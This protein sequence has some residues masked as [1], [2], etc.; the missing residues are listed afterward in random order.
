M[1]S[2]L[3]IPIVAA[4][5]LV[6]LAPGGAVEAR[7]DEG[8]ELARRVAEACGVDAFDDLA[9]LR[10]TWRHEPSGTVRSYDWD[11]A[12]RTV[13]VTVGEETVTVGVDGPRSEDDR[14]AHAAFVNDSYWLLFELH[15]EWDEAVEMQALGPI[16]VPAFD[17]FGPVPALSVQYLGDAGYTPGDRYVLYLGPDDRPVAWAYHPEGTPEPRLVT[18]REEWKKV[19][20][21]NVPT[22]F[23]RADGT[24]FITI[25]DIAAE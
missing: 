2:L 17:D 5:H 7:A 1:K 23:R 24:V 11:V 3:L 10:F 15:L 19:A 9:R 14:Q 16:D 25:T 18:T 12:D 22:T 13:E 6:A 20:G 4:L 8:E 21:L